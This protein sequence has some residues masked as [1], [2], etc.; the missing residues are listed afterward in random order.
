MY[1]SAYKSLA[2][3]GR[4]QATATRLTFA[5]HPQKKIQKVVR[6]TRSP[7]QEWP[8]RRTKNGDFSIVFSV[9]SGWGLISTPVLSK[10]MASDSKATNKGTHNKATKPLDTSAAVACACPVTT[11]FFHSP[12]PCHSLPECQHHTV[13]RITGQNPTGSSQSSVSIQAGP[14]TVCTVYTAHNLDTAS[15]YWYS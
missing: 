8:P 4:K 6:P 14:S 10:M 12:S 5:S 2:R 13:K 11:T 9:G 7:Q 1:R 15:T 3:P